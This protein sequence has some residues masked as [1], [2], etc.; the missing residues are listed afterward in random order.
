MTSIP[1]IAATVLTN[2]S[3]AFWLVNTRP[4]WRYQSQWG[5]MLWIIRPSQ[6]H[7]HSK[8][9][10]QPWRVSALGRVCDGTVQGNLTHVTFK[11][12]ETSVTLES[13]C[14]MQVGRPILLQ[15]HPLEYQPRMERINDNPPTKGIACYTVSRILWA[16]GL[17]HPHKL[18]TRAQNQT[19]YHLQQVFTTIPS[20]VHVDSYSIQ[21]NRLE[22][23]A[24][25]TCLFFEFIFVPL[26][27]SPSQWIFCWPSMGN[28]VR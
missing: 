22:R 20:E 11:T 17:S 15:F 14:V 3:T 26:T 7:R 28:I 23:D 16:N 27:R 21:P 24:T 10:K 18:D 6:S 8:P 9:N 1:C 2:A 12:R 25:S 4:A 5:N 13:N 19:Q